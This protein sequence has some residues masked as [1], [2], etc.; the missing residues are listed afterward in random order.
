[1]AIAMVLSWEWVSFYPSQRAV[2]PNECVCVCV[3]VCLCVGRVL[4]S[5]FLH[6]DAA[7]ARKQ[8]NS[9][10][11]LKLVNDISLIRR[12][13][14][15]GSVSHRYWLFISVIAV[16][17]FFSFVIFC[18]SIHW[19]GTDRSGFLS[20]SVRF[21]FGSGFLFPSFLFFSFLFFS[22]LFFSFFLFFLFRFLM[23]MDWKK[24]MSSS[25]SSSML[26]ICDR[27]DWFLFQTL[28]PSPC[29]S[30][31]PPSSFLR[32][33]SSVLLSPSSVLLLWNSSIDRDE[34]NQRAFP[35]WRRY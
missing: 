2:S 7:N 16:S 6:T 29:L 13:V 30:H 34:P 1:M 27:N 24:S 26:I 19:W 33:P 8:K 12:S 10:S 5:A 31:L 20:G 9:W 25:S 14:V 18:Y 15:L 21:G 11:L 28:L 23:G 22:F 35:D 32:P 3:C 17:F 4:I